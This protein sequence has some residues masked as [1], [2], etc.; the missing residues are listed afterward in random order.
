M[1][2]IPSGSCVPF[3]DKPFQV[4]VMLPASC[5]PN[6]CVSTIFPELSVTVIVIV[7]APLGKL[8]DVLTG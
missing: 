3:V 6:D 4:A 2:Y 5:D 8:T 7:C 1:L